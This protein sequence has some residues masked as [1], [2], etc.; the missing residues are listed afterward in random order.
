[1]LPPCHHVPFV[2]C[3]WVAE[4]LTVATPRRSRSRSGRRVSSRRVLSDLTVCPSPGRRVSTS[5]NDPGDDE[6]LLSGN[7]PEA[8]P[9]PPR[10]RRGAWDWPSLT[11]STRP[12]SIPP[13][14]WEGRRSVGPWDRGHDT[15]GDP[16]PDSKPL[17]PQ[18]TPNLIPR[19]SPGGMT[20]LLHQAE[21]TTPVRYHNPRGVYSYGMGT[22]AEVALVRDHV[23]AGATSA[24]GRREHAAMLVLLVADVKCHRNIDNDEG[25]R[26][27]NHGA[28]RR[29]GFVRHGGKGR[30]GIYLVGPAVA[31]TSRA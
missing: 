31:E 13:T 24:A 4:G 19:S 28:R 7:H 22:S 27:L 2:R 5:Y 6:A 26:G 23:A 15:A 21:R 29:A 8:L 14:R 30:E 1:M 16:A 12:A 20:R 10:R 18:P 9:F 17:I 25:V 3:R 11:S